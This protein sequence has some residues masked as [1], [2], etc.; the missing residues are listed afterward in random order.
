MKREASNKISA[1]QALRALRLGG[2]IAYPTE[3]VWGLGC[4]PENF[5]AIERLLALKRRSPNKGLILIA[6][7][8]S[9]FVHWIGLDWCVWLIQQ[10]PELPTTWVVPCLPSTPAWLTGGRKTLAVR[11]VKEGIAGE[12]AAQFGPIVSTSANLSGKRE[13]RQMW[14]IR[15]QFGE[16]L[17]YIVPGTPGGERP[18]RVI[19]A[20]TGRVL[21]T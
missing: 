3:T 6:A 16:A 14:Q 5:Q 8:A 12:I 11:V 13:L 18:S 10:N 15:M 2:V 9:D 1:I 19:E 4:D 17:D 20:Q 21:R 7:D